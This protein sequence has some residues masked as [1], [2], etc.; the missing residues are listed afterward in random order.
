[1]YAFNT[2]GS[3]FGSL[4][5]GFI[6]IPVLG[7][8]LSLQLISAI[9]FF[10]VAAIVIKYTSFT[11][12]IYEHLFLVIVFSVL[13]FAIS[14]RD[15]EFR[16]LPEGT[17]VLFAKEGISA[18][19]KVLKDESGE[20]SLY[21]NEKQQG[22]TR[23]EQTE[24]WTGQVPMIIHGK[25]DSVLLIGLGTGVTLNAL[26]EGP[27]GHVTCVDLIGSLKSA[28]DYFGSIN[29]NVL[30]KTDQV[31][32]VEADGINYLKLV[33]ARYDLILCDIVHPDD[34]G[35]GDLYSLEFYENCRSRLKEDGLFSQW[36]LLEQLAPEDLNIIMATF[37]KVFPGMQIYLGQD[38]GQ[39]QKLMLAG[40]K[41]GNMIRLE[42]IT[43]N[44][45]QMS[46]TD[47]FTG[48][49]DSYSFLSYFV[50][51]GKSLQ[52]LLA[53]VKI[54]SRD[55]PIIEY[56][57]P[58][59]KWLNAKSIRNLSY[60]NTLRKPIVNFLP[61]IDT[62]DSTL[63][64]TYFNARTHLINGRLQENTFEY[65]AA[66]ISYSEAALL[67]VDTLLT[68]D[69]LA[70]NAWNLVRESNFELAITAFKKS[71]AVNHLN[72]RASFSLAELLLN[73]GRKAEAKE[74]YLYTVHYDPNHADAFRRL[75]DIYSGRKEFDNAFYAYR[76]S[77]EADDNQ[78][79]IHYIL[80]QIYFN[81]KKDYPN[82]VR[83]FQKSLELNP[84]HH[85][86]REA[87]EMLRKIEAMLTKQG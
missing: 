52:N 82:A 77:L 85:Y 53:S 68:S 3:I 47:E 50:T 42:E 80:G 84:S 87:R 54:N 28:V 79:V 2:V 46:F 51:D 86:N 43:K 71:L 13:F 65:K 75:G 4:I 49:T 72:V 35:A 76:M 12:N 1:V 83:R 73:Q 17:T 29:D 27:V 69:L 40:S 9:A 78:P 24:R 32:F 60:L 81:Y 63:F 14:T 56:Q 7:I 64:T 37:K 61:G 67:D 21:I 19:V 34:V 23:V 39:S 20:I 36:M 10:V 48:K 41:N 26:T 38:R 22:G 15:G 30:R 11:K 58:K 45:Q 31:T 59:N 70:N 33:P 57:S 18:E 25:A 16:P 5:T 62:A 66:D 44:L 74:F 55:H 6:L 8:V